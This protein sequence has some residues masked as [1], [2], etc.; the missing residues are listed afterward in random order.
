MRSERAQMS[1]EAQIK[2]K[3]N[4]TKSKQNSQP[5]IIL[6]AE[7]M[8][9]NNHHAPPTSTA[10]PLHLGMII[11]LYPTLSHFALCRFPHPAKVV[12]WE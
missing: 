3:Q 6:T 4:K 12:G 9:P 10:K 11:F 8:N 7:K 1:I 2:K 5:Q